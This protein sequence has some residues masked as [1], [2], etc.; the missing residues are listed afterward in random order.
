MTNV[1]TL[2]HSTII[3]FKEETGRCYSTTHVH[4]Q[5]LLDSYLGISFRGGR[6]HIHLKSVNNG[7][8]LPL[9]GRF[10]RDK[11]NDWNCIV[12]VCAGD[13]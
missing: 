11:E 6:C 12:K 7:E 3:F 8:L 1:P 13:D 10:A 4:V 5:V 9:A 2:V